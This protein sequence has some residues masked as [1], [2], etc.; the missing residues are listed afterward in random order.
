VSDFMDAAY[1]LWNSLPSGLAALI[2]LVLGWLAAVSLRFLAAKLMALVRFDRLSERTGLSE[3]LRKGGVA[4]SPSRLVGAIAYW[5]VLAL[6]LY[7]TAKSLDVR[8]ADTIADK[9]VDF[10]PSLLA[11]ALVAIL[12][13]ILVSFLANFAMTIARN[14]GTPHGRLISRAIRA[15]GY[16]VVVSLALE[17]L[18]LGRT[19]LSMI[20]V[21]L[22]A[23]V[24]LGCALAFG[25]GSVDLAKGAMQRFIRNLEE[26]GRG[27]KGGDLEG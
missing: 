23:A 17:Q 26:R 20:F 7:L 16:L 13:A 24:A 19:V 12:G 27:S 9:V 14:A 22:F 25:L 4:Y 18:G 21:I 3:F 8:I 2:T 10:L 11:S 15:I 5:I 1:R 6:A